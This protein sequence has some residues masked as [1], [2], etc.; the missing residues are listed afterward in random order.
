MMSR[1]GLMVPAAGGG[2]FTTTWKPAQT[3]LSTVAGESSLAWVNSATLAALNGS[4]LSADDG[5]FAYCDVPAETLTQSLRARNFGFTSADVPSGATLLGVAVR[6]TRYAS[7]G[8]ALQE[9]LVQ[10]VTGTAGTTAD[11]IGASLATGASLPASEAAATYGGPTNMWGS[12]AAVITPAVVTS[13][14]FGV[15]IRLR[16]VA[17]AGA[18]GRY[19]LVECQLYGTT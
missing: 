5:A 6:L 7:A 3:C 2:P 8:S 9:F 1:A 17:G 10:L 19:D 14:A 13:A 12:S 11:R 18:I 15:D 16:E 4:E